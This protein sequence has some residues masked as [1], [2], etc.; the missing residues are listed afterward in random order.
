MNIFPV[1]VGLAVWSLCPFGQAADAAAVQT[2]RKLYED[3]QGAV[4]AVTAVIKVQVSVSGGGNQA[5]EQTAEMMGTVINDQGLTVVNYSTLDVSSQVRSQ[6]K[7]KLPPGMKVDIKAE[8]K[9][10]KIVTS[11]GDEVPGDVVMKDPDLDLAFIKPDPNSDEFKNTKFAPIHLV[12]PPAEPAILDEVIL[13]DRRGKEVNRRP[14]VSFAR[15]VGIQTKPRTYYLLDS[16]NSGTPVFDLQGNLLGIFARRMFEGAATSTI[17][18]PVKDV[19]DIAKQ[20]EAAKAPEKSKP[21]AGGAQEESKPAEMSA[22]ESKPTPPSESEKSSAP[23][24]Q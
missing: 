23:P 15:I 7:G 18:L 20:A 9:E 8:F 11:D 16:Q 14:T 2:A 22:Q 6:L 3:R 19:A 13:L 10:V 21:E 24:P 12:L 17:V 4:V 5:Q 1:I